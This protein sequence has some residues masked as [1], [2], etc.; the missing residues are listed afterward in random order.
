MD[1]PT[2]VFMKAQLGTLPSWSEAASQELWD[3]LAI[4]AGEDINLALKRDGTV[5]AWGA[6]GLFGG[7]GRATVPDGL[8][9]V[10][11]IAAGSGYCLAITT[12]AAVA[13][14]FRQRNN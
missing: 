11:A 2:L 13:E 14:K 12:N 6:V 1:D 10:V 9:S 8:S 4:A 7:Y 3:T 5:V